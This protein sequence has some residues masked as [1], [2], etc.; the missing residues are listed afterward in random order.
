MDTVALRNF[1]VYAS[2]VAESSGRCSYL[3][4]HAGLSLGVAR[5]APLHPNGRWH[6]RVIACA[7]A[8]ED[9]SCACGC[10]CACGVHEC[11]HVRMCVRECPRECPRVCLRVCARV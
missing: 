7:Q 4:A 9:S 2:R 1:L 6:T 8:H 11:V 10:A 5:L 3:V